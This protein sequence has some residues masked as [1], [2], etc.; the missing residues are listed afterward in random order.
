MAEV[1]VLYGGTPI[2]CKRFL[3]IEPEN[4]TKKNRGMANLGWDGWNGPGRE[5]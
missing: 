2:G 4:K 5:Q 3:P 1:L